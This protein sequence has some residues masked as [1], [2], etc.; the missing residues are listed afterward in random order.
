MRKFVCLAFCW[1]SLISPAWAESAFTD[2][3]YTL[4]KDGVLDSSDYQYLNS[5][6]HALGT[7]E[8]ERYFSDQFLSYLKRH[9]NLTRLKY[10]YRKQ[11]RLYTMNFVFSPTYSESQ[12]IPGNQ[13][14]TVLS[15]IS[16]HDNLKE[17]R[18]DGNRC[19]AATL[20]NA[21]YYLHY[22]FHGAFQKLGITPQY[23]VSVTY[24]DIHLAQ[25]KLYTYAN[26]DRQ[27]GLVAGTKYSYYSSG[28]I[29]NV[30]PH[31]EILRGATLLGLKLH[32]LMG[33]T[34]QQA[35]QRSSTVEQ[36][37]KKHRR[38]ALMVGVHL[39]P[40][41]GKLSVPTS[42]NAQNHFVLVLK[43]R[44]RYYLLNTGVVNN[45]DGSALKSLSQNE[46][47]SFI[48]NTN[49]IVHGVTR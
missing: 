4:I 28:A 10:K 2:A 21:Y 45:G 41:S 40:Q 1:G 24:K 48:Y 46:V 49:G 32:P 5:N 14:R 36:F 33:P 35:Y 8:F 19:G 16:Q 9:R 47:K 18:E 42:F 25:E 31:G 38:G 30:R 22:D 44:G 15:H 11:G 7:N 29:F 37:W 23:S 34:Q 6:R 17:T 13:T 26:T 27:A 20:L 43:D 12:R 3:V 39:N